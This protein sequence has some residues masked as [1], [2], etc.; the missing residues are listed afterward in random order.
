MPAVAVRRKAS[1]LFI[2]IWRK[3]CVDG[4]LNFSLNSILKLWYFVL[5]F[6]NFESCREGGG[7]L[8]VKVTI[9]DR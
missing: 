6:L 8:T 7:I 3:G 5:I 9:N 4:F 2:V 1:V